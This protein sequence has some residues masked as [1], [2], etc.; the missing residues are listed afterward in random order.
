MEIAQAAYQL[1]FVRLFHETPPA[2]RQREDVPARRHRFV[3]E[4]VPGMKNTCFSYDERNRELI[5]EKA[6]PLRLRPQQMPVRE[7]ESP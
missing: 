7:I 2:E 1:H 6:A 3:L 5:A 4:N